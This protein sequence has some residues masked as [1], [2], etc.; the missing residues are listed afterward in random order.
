MKETRWSNCLDELLAQ[1]GRTNYDVV[2]S[3]KS[4]PWK[5]ELAVILRKEEGAAIGWIAGALAMG[6]FIAPQL[7]LSLRSISNVTN[8]G[9]TPSG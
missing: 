5:V 2:Q 7:P 1:T 6:T 9:L 4:V 8:H 3:R